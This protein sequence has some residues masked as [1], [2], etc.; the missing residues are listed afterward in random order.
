MGKVTVRCRRGVG[1]AKASIGAL[2]ASVPLVACGE[3]ARDAQLM[4]S[5]AGSS[6]SARRTLVSYGRRTISGDLGAYWSSEI[7][8]P[9]DGIVLVGPVPETAP[10]LPTSLMLKLDVRGFTAVRATTASGHAYEFAATRL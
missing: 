3:H 2:A 7:S 4:T 10:E 5:A 8:G 6:S 1:C 9:T